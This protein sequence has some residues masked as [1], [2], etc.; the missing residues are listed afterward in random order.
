[1]GALCCK[2]EVRNA[3][4]TLQSVP[5]ADTAVVAF[6]PCRRSTLTVPSTF[7]TSISCD[8]S[9]REHLARFVA[10]PLFPYRLPSAAVQDERE[11]LRGSCTHASKR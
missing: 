9:G 3:L 4:S 8:Q 2:P 6:P 10:L 1:M 11:K 5:Q 7:G